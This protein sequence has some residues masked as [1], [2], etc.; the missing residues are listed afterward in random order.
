MKAKQTAVSKIKKLSDYK[1]LD[2]IITHVDLCIDI[3][4]DPITSFAKLTVVPSPTNKPAENTSLVLDGQNIDLKSLQLN[5]QPLEPN[6]YSLTDDSLT[7]M[8]PPKNESFTVEMTCELR[9]NTDL[10]G[11]YETEGV[12]LVK[13]ETEGLR[14][15]FYFQDRPDNLSTYKTTIIA[16]KDDYPVL[17]SN[18][19]MKGTEELSMGRHAVTWYDSLPKPSYLFALVAGKL[20]QTIAYFKSKTGKALPIEFFVPKHALSSCEFAKKV[21]Q[22]ALKWDEEKLNLP[23]DLEHLMVAGVDKY[24]SGASEPTGLILFNTANLYADSKSK[25]DLDRLRVLEVVAH[26]YFHYWSGNRVTIRDWFNLPLKEG[27]TTFR[28]AMFREELF[29]TDLIRLLDGKNLDERAPR[30]SSYTTVRS[31]YTAAAYEKS[32][33]IFRMM[34]LVIGKKKFFKG[35]T[36]FF[37]QYDGTA[38]TIETFLESMTKS[39]RHDVRSFLTWFTES[40]IPTVVITDEYNEKK[41]LYV[42]KIRVKN[43]KDRPIPMLFGLLG[44][45]GTEYISD[46]M[47]LLNSD[48]TTL[49]YS[50]IPTR[51]TPSLFRSFSAPVNIQYDYRKSDLVL[52]MTHDSNLYNRSEAAK[53]LI[54]SYVTDFCNGKV[55][56]LTSEVIQAYKTILND[57]KLSEW[58]KAELISL[59]SLEDIISTQT[60][61]NIEKTAEALQLIRGHLAKSL[62]GDLHKCCFH[63]QLQDYRADDADQL[64][65]MKNAGLRRLLNTCYSY[66]AVAIPDRTKDVLINQFE[67]SLRKNMTETISALSLVCEMNCPESEQLLEQFYNYWQDDP[68]AVNNWFKLQAANHSVNVVE[69]VEKLLTHSA[70]DLSNP[71]KVYS[72]LL[73]FINNPYGFHASSGKGYSLIEDQILKLDKINPTLAIRL[74]ENYSRCDK[75]DENRF[76]MM[77]ASL[78]NIATKATSEDVRNAAKKILDKPK[79]I[80][81]IPIA[82]TMH[83]RSAD[84]SR[85]QGKNEEQK[86]LSLFL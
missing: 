39:T 49:I 29:G 43:A 44:A 64:F 54:T 38:E 7:L 27:L 76:K 8:N 66:L 73:T 25:T 62:Q 79:E 74:T 85:K 16:F 28:A 47:R 60:K 70:F 53:S 26:E 65:D 72:L 33:D 20:E 21:L 23:C 34:M 86:K 6:S 42:L 69:R 2:Y 17:L 58:M 19:I 84:K 11:L 15:V 3:S 68:G 30:Q 59:P 14:R 82:L 36:Q 61:P 1:P 24:P 55:I 10:F 83:G 48:E 12:V 22:N 52:L 4:R 46:N 41:Q 80:P 81:P 9:E 35:L 5:G 67:D 63:I 77:L 13:A 71:N 32:A 18:G 75:Y 56:N 78:K 45:D 50:D 31:L 57:P 51:P 37:T 40:E